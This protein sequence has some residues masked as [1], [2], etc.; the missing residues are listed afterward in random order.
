[1]FK[2]KVRNWPDSVNDWPEIKLFDEDFRYPL[3]NLYKAIC[4]HDLWKY[5]CENPPNPDLGYMFS[6][7]DY[8]I[9]K[10][11]K[12]PLVLRYK[13]TKGSFGYSM[14]IMENISHN[15]FNN[16]VKDWVFTSKE[17]NAKQKMKDKDLDY[18]VLNYANEDNAGF[19]SNTNHV[20]IFSKDGSQKELSLD[21][22]DRISS[23]LIDF[24][25]NNK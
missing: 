7:N 3:H 14:R 15:G 12:D 19:E 20:I 6:N 11:K 10:L 8:H 4:K 1:M 17:Y 2:K 23:K 5:I 22:K 13:H 24:I 9:N 18:I 21:R 25:I 16:F